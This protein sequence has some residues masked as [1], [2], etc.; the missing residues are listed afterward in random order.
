MPVKKT[1]LI[2]GCSAGGIG[3]SLALEF[4]RRGLHVF[5]TARSVD[6]MSALASAG[7]TCLALDTTSAESI[8]AAVAQVDKAISGSGVSAGGGRSSSTGGGL[9]YLINN[10]GIVHVRP[11]LDSTMD[12]IR[13]V[14]DTNLVGVMAVTHAFLPMLIRARGVIATIGSINEVFL[15]PFQTSYNATKAAVHVWSNSLRMELKPL[16]VRV[17]TVVTGA[18]RSKLM[19]NEA[20][21]NA[22]GGGG[23][24]DGKSEPFPEGSYYKPCESWIRDREF[25]KTAQWQET[26]A[27]ARDVVAALL[28][29]EPKHTLWK[30]GMATIAWMVNLLGWEGMMDGVFSNQ[31]RLNQIKV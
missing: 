1:V 24:H 5:A 19:E 14:I 4:H 20:E 30:G 8:A 12:E 28:K 27:Y 6:K 25:L 26:D 31:S 21:R 17:V 29:E 23:G 13:R 11:F 7:I 9:D 22:G 18:V 10:A 3:A 15:P 2:T 16:G